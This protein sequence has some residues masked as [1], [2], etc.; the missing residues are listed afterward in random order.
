MS[1]VGKSPVAVPKD[2]QVELKGSEITIRGKLGVLKSPITGDVKVVYEKGEA[3]SDAFISVQP[4]NDS[5]I[6]RAMWGTTRN[7]INNMVKGVSEGFKVRLEITG[8][9][10]RAAAEG[11]MLSLALGFSHEIRYAVPAGISI[12]CEKPTLIVISGSDKQKVGQIA[13][14]IMKYRPVEPYKGKGVY[15][16]GSKIRRKEGK[17]K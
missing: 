2:V 13:G 4:A 16:E 11:N 8:V 9:G 6:S 17:K 3:G 5:Q 10:F 7:N 1:R 14:E 12:A 15:I